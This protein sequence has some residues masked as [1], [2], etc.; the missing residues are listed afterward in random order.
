MYRALTLDRRHLSDLERECVWVALLAAL[1]EG[2][3][4]HH[5]R[6]FRAAG[7]DDTMAAALFRLAA[8]SHGAAVH[9]FLGGDWARHVPGFDPARSY[10]DG[11]ATLAADLPPGVARLA[12]LAIHAARDEPWGLR[13]DLEAAYD[14]ATPETKMAEA[15]SLAIWPRGVNPFVRACAIWLDLLRFGRVA[16]SPPFAAWRDTPDQ[17]ALRLDP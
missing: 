16:P 17:G 2:V 14:E 8:W 4:T 3:G 5:L 11:A 15:I 7:G 10:R 9:R 13:T 12:L 6:A 1:G